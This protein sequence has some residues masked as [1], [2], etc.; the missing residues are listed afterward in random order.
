MDTGTEELAAGRVRVQ[1]PHFADTCGMASADA[2]HSSKVDVG[3]VEVS[4]GNDV[5][6]MAS[7]EVSAV[8]VVCEGRHAW[9]CVD[10]TCPP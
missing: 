6:R 1:A 3:G 5:C 8:A 9:A 4:E 10:R 2:A 7:K